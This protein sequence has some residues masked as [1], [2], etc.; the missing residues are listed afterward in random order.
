MGQCQDCTPPSLRRAQNAQGLCHVPEA[1]T[2]TAPS[3]SSHARSWRG[4]PNLGPVRSRSHIGLA[5]SLLRPQHRCSQAQDLLNGQ[6]ALLIQKIGGST[7]VEQPYFWNANPALTPSNPKLQSW[8][9][10]LRPKTPETPTPC[11]QEDLLEQ[12]GTSEA[13]LGRGRLWFADKV[14]A[15]A[16]L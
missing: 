16:A 1:Q 10:T 13:V 14:P 15:P 8:A 9:V 3:T 5:S 7:R 4:W 6:S 11:Y 12:D 2:S